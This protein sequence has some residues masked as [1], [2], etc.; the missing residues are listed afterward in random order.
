MNSIEAVSRDLMALPARQ[1]VGVLLLV[2]EICPL[3]VN[4]IDADGDPHAE[5]ILDAIRAIVDRGERVTWAGV[6]QAIESIDVGCGVS[7][8]DRV[9]MAIVHEMFRD[10]PD[11]MN[12]ALRDAVA[13]VASADAGF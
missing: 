3:V 5:I 4:S 9:D 1:R 8:M 11:E 7:Q 6:C 13:L 10:V 12:A 2:P